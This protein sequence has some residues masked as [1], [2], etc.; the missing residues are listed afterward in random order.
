VKNIR[1]LFVEDSQEDVML[2]LNEIRRAGFEPTRLQV[3]KADA[4][5]RAIDSADWDLIISDEGTPSFGAAEALKIAIESGKDIPF[6]I[7]SEKIDEDSAVAA[8]RFGAHDFINKNNL[9]RLVPAIE[10]ELAEAAERK[11]RRRMEQSVQK[12]ESR[13]RM[14]FEKMMDAF[15]LHVDVR[16]RDGRL[17]DFMFLDANHAYTV[18]TGLSRKNLIGKTIREIDPSAGDEII[19]RYARV[20]ETGDSDHFVYHSDTFGKYFEVSVYRP[21]EGLTA[22]V[23]RDVS[24]LKITTER[25]ALFNDILQTLNRE[26]NTPAIIQDILRLL[27]DHFCFDAV[28]IRLRQGE[29]YPYYLHEGFPGSF[30]E[31]QSLLCVKNESGDI[32]RH[33]DGAP[34]LSCLCG[35]VISGKNAAAR[36]LLTKGGSLW[37]NSLS[38]LMADEAESLSDLPLREQC[39]KEGY[40]SMALIPL[41]S[42]DET[43]G[44]LQFNDRKKNKFGPDTIEFLESMGLTVG[45]ALK[46]R[47][48]EGEIRKSEGRYRTI[49]EDI[50]DGYYEVDLEGNLVFFNDALCRIYGYSSDELM[51]MNNREYTSPETSRKAFKIFN[52]VYITGK[53]SKVFDW[54]LIKKDGSKIYVEISVS[55]IRDTGG[56]GTGFRGI[57]RD[58]SERKRAEETLRESENRYRAIFDGS[59][60]LIYLH[61]FEGNF[62]DAN[63]AALRSLG[64]NREEVSSIT[65][66][67][68]LSPDQQQKAYEQIVNILENTG[69]SEIMEYQLRTK[70]GNTIVVEISAAPL[71]RDG[72]PYAIL[73]VARDITE[74]K[75]DEE[76]MLASLR[77]KEALL[78]EI[79]HRVKNNLQV[80]S[81][82]M[83]L[84]S[85]HIGKGQ[86]AQTAL[87]DM[88]NRIKSM[89]IVH[90]KLYQSENF[91]GIDFGEYIASIAESISLSLLMGEG[92]IRLITD[93]ESVTLG[94]DEAVP[95]GLILNELITNAVKHAFPADRA[96][97]ITAGIRKSGD[98]LVT[99]FVGDDGVGLSAD[100]NIDS[101]ATLGIRL[102]QILTKQLDGT[103]TIGHDKGTEFRISFRD[104]IKKQKT[105]QG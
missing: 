103:M 81:S 100:Y 41:I 35:L 70:K 11:M 99:I 72:K 16:D 34:R 69:K 79:H 7:V 54:E 87:G 42:G 83:G 49:L 51:G 78:R 40:E 62:L 12:S 101:A 30:I 98:G 4:M 82:L 86:N 14:L 15:M 36:S 77:E 50:E 9:K 60:N 45:I 48:S 104:G 73:G 44:I 80:I 31:S 33:D 22:T 93:A 2:I 74:R 19:D 47:Q 67:D 57:V 76:R 65:I 43:I 97:R 89:A 27:K 53:P 56:V 8:M 58:I 90:E 85:T 75:L 84:Q 10:R 66:K 21:R 94:I 37:T 105:S 6:I 52:E 25:Q 32:V 38:G 13:Y 46:R 88:Q 26:D 68:L 39:L 71:Y 55:L 64:Y 20:M 24:L 91:A 92:R 1:I 59:L 23:L 102:V 61:D 18:I 17:T 29:D 63:D 95:C 96:G 28:A 3:E 5:Q